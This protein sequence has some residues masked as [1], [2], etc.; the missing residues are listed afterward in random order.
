MRARRRK[1]RLGVRLNDQDRDRIEAV[2]HGGV[3]KVRAVC[4]AQ[5]LRLLD[6]GATP[7]QAGRAVGVSAV[8]VTARAVGWR[9][10]EQGLERAVSGGK[11]PGKPPLL[12]LA[13]RQ[14]IVAMACGRAPA[15]YA[16]CRVGE[17]VSALTPHRPG[18][19]QLRHPV[20]H[21]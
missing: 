16:R 7:P 6:R 14:R 12:T 3:L 15:G 5:I 9:Y 11:A 18:R 1:R 4:R 2:L 8:A 21:A 17:D 20:L 19:A 13:Q 10:C